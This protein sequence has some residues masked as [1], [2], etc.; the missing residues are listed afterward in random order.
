MSL[1]DFREEFG[2]S[3]CKIGISL[4]KKCGRLINNVQDGII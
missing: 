4:P 3:L 1:I 2:L